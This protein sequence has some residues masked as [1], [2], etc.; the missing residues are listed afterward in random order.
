VDLTSKEKKAL[1]RGLRAIQA[2]REF[3]ISLER[4]LWLHKARRERVAAKFRQRLLK[5]ALRAANVDPAAITL[6][7]QLDHRS[8][9]AHLKTLMPMINAHSRTISRGHAGRI[10]SLKVLAK[11]KQPPRFL[12]PPPLPPGVPVETVLLNQAHDRTLWYGPG[13]T[14]L[15]PWNNTLR[16]TVAATSRDGQDF[17]VRCDFSFY[18][19][20][21]RSGNLHVWAFVAANGIVLWATDA[22][23][24]SLSVVKAG[25]FASVT[26][27]QA[28]T[29]GNISHID[30]PDQPLGPE[31]DVWRTVNCSSDYGVRSYDSFLTFE[32]TAMEFPVVAMNPVQVVVSIVLGGLVGSATCGFDFQTKNRQINVPAVIL[33][34]L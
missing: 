30:L 23:C 10:A 11:G 29:S 4:K 16:T 9:Q 32:T 5:S 18:F 21:S 22:L 34:L 17:G 31:V 19:R 33:N 20:P 3:A 1:E 28:D 7:Q 13:T 14:N 26:L 25:G 2:E 6:R 8:A 15:A 27:Q 24:E 12:A